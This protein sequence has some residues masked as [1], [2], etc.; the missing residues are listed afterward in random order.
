MAVIEWVSNGLTTQPKLKFY[1][2]STF[3][4]TTWVWMNIQENYPSGKYSLMKVS[5]FYSTLHFFLNFFKSETSSEGCQAMSEW[6][7][8]GLSKLAC[9]PSTIWHLHQRWGWG[10]W[11][12][13]SPHPTPPHPTPPHL[14]LSAD[15]DRQ[16]SSK[17]RRE[18]NYPQLWHWSGHHILCSFELNGVIAD[19]P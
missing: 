3:T 13:N 10:L 19:L 16:S 14:C 4:I 9:S 8:R 12:G 6:W 15:T 7:I 18:H 1:L 5:Y 11:I 2:H 17:S